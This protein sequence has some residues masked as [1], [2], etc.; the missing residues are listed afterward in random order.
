MGYHFFAS[1]LSWIVL[2]QNGVSLFCVFFVQKLIMRDTYYSH[3]IHG[4]AGYIIIQQ[5][6]SKLEQGNH[7]CPPHP[8]NIAN[9]ILVMYIVQYNI[10]QHNTVGCPGRQVVCLY[11]NI[12]GRLGR[13]VVYK[14]QPFTI[15][16]LLYYIAIMY[17][18][19]ATIC[20]RFICICVIQVH[21]EQLFQQYQQEFITQNRQHGSDQLFRQI[22]IFLQFFTFRCIMFVFNLRILLL[23]YILLEYCKNIRHLSCI[24]SRNVVRFFIYVQIGT[25]C[26]TQYSQFAFRNFLVGATKQKYNFLLKIQN[27]NNILQ[28]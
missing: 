3:I 16:I 9:I 5:N 25:Q 11:Y 22:L 20:T 6:I 10:I 21:L 12:T 23:V 27:N 19:Y 17:S 15:L 4:H 8:I 14:P 18:N 24:F 7:Y 1:F 28:Q 13:Q 26:N 2:G